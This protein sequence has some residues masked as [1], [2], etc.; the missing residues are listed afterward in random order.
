[1]RQSI[2]RKNGNKPQ[3]IIAGYAFQK[4][5][6]FKMLRDNDIII[7]GLRAHISYGLP[8]LDISIFGPLK[9]DLWLLRSL[10]TVSTTKETGNDV[11]TILELF[12]K[13]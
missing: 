9:E 3:F 12:K 6:Q 10:C 5:K 1:M 8:P 13:C 7:V 2:L 4:T 11:F